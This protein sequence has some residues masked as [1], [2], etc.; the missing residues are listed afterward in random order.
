MIIYPSLEANNS[1][2][3]LASWGIV[4]LLS[5]FA[6]FDD[7]MGG[8]GDWLSDLLEFKTEV[9]HLHWVVWHI[10][11]VAIIVVILWVLEMHVVLL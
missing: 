11:V 8:L 6:D 3:N 1:N 7:G 2:S 10:L 4:N 9:L 5:L